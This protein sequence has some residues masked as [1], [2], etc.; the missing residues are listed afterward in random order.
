[1]FVPHNNKDYAPR[2]LNIVT[3][4]GSTQTQAGITLRGLIASG[5]DMKVVATS[6]GGT[7]RLRLRPRSAA[8]GRPEGPGAHGGRRAA[9]VAM[10]IMMAAGLALAV[11]IVPSAFP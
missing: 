6:T 8:L 5:S 4:T 9:A 1:M 7:R 2:W 10:T 3:N 11:A